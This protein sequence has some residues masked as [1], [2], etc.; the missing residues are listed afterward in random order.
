MLF[1][2]R[3]FFLAILTTF[4]LLECPTRVSNGKF[5]IKI[6]EIFHTT[7]Y[8]YSQRISQ[9]S[10]HIVEHKHSVFQILPFSNFPKVFR[11]SHWVFKFNQVFNQVFCSFSQF[12]KVF[13]YLLQIFFDFSEFFTVFQ[14]IPRPYISLMLNQWIRITRVS[15]RVIYCKSHSMEFLMVGDGMNNFVVIKIVNDWIG[16]VFLV[17]FTA[18]Q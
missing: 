5:P 3:I 17:V 9:I 1:T 12:F 13:Q 11:V 7:K 6:T 14:N 15:T 10:V 2:C 18:K 8:S 16:R 4:E